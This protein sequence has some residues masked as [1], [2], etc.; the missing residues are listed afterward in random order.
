LDLNIELSTN[1]PLDEIRDL[2]NDIMHSK[3][4]TELTNYTIAHLIFNFR[5]FEKFRNSFY[6]LFEG[7]KKNYT[8]IDIIDKQNLNL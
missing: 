5:S 7:L 1:H 8:T 6:S 4:A 3:I 2:R